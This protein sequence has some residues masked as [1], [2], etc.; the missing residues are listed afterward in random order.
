MVVLFFFYQ[1][2]F[3]S[4]FSNLNFDIPFVNLGISKKGLHK[5]F[6]SVG[7]EIVMLAQY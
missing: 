5:G 2:V 1:R 7:I 6:P 4:N 3:F